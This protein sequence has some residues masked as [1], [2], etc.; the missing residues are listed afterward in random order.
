MKVTLE[1]EKL[2][3][4]IVEIIQGL[5]DDGKRAVAEVLHMDEELCLFITAHLTDSNDKYELESFW[6]DYAG[7]VIEKMRMNVAA[8]LPEV[9]FQILRHAIKDRDD[10][11]ASRDAWQ[12]MM[13]HWRNSVSQCDECRKD[14]CDAH[15]RC[16]Y[17]SPE[18]AWAPYPPRE[19]VDA[20]IAEME[21]DPK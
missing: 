7:G 19:E 13:R 2:T 9:Q 16:L 21:A 12:R 6:C 4:D 8:L 20:Y 11:I 15:R 14:V 17:D 18:H 1:R 5:D 3:L 10:A